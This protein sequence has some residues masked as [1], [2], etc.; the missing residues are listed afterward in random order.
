M[1]NALIFGV[2]GQD[3]YYLTELCKA[4]GIEPIGI[5]RKNTVYQGDVGRYE[6]VESFIR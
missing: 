1:A 3:G 2:T 5:S 6:H 4:R